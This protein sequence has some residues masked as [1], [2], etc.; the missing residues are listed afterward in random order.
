MFTVAAYGILGSSTILLV[1]F[2]VKFMASLGQFRAKRHYEAASDIP[3]VSICI[4][5][6]NETHA[7]AECLERVL[8]T[9]YSKLEILVLDDNSKD[10]TSII[11]KS[12]AHA[13]VRFIPGESVPEGWLGKN[14]ALH[15]L[16]SEASGTYIVFMDV[17]TFVKPQTISQLVAAITTEKRDMVSVLPRRN[18][19]G[20]ASVFFGT[21]RYFW[22]LA[23]WQ[24]KQAA[25]SSL[26]MIRRDV[27]LEKLHGLE[28]Y[29][30]AV[31]PEVR[32]AADLKDSYVY[33]LSND[34]LGVAYEKKWSSQAETSKRLLY[35]LFGQHVGGGVLGILILLV[36]AAPGVFVVASL[37][38]GWSLVASLAAIILIL[39]V[40]LYGLYLRQTWRT[41]WWLGAF[42][43]PV[44]ILQELF[45]LVASIYGYVRKTITWKSRSIRS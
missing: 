24:Y 40:A 22:Q 15:R 28:V 19:S 12:F 33:L 7:L 41:L 8:A 13:G 36:L 23:G 39:F 38:V 29:K 32:V 17:D 31:E 18:D 26:W 6:R 16:A 5:A 4:P 37:V 11:I 25:S 3:S 27:L 2:Y 1:F 44:I 14:Y 21:L 9:S 10:D 20:R 30:D 35:P 42:L 45:L 43:W 34:D